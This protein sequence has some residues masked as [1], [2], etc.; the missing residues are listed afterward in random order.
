MELS[1]AE[2]AARDELIDSFALKGWTSVY[3]LVASLTTTKTNV[4]VCVCTN[5]CGWIIPVHDNK[6]EGNQR[7]ISRSKTRIDRSAACSLR[8]VNI[9]CHNRELSS[10]QLLFLLKL[11]DCAT[12]AL[13]VLWPKFPIF[14]EKGWKCKP[15]LTNTARTKFDIKLVSL[16]RTKS[17]P[18][19]F[20]PAALCCSCSYPGT[21]PQ[22]KSTK[23]LGNPFIQT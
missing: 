1:Q 8:K 15:G 9:C 18:A 20:D 2:A 4:L 19:L 3:W 5:C 6:L 10:H 16:N 7:G 14:A 11:L 21:P 23:T 22:K 12:R 17:D 13:P